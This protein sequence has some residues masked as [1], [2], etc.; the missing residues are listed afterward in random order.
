MT[1]DRRPTR[2]ARLI[3]QPTEAT[4]HDAPTELA[5]TPGCLLDIPSDYLDETAEHKAARRKEAILTLVADWYGSYLVGRPSAVDHQA[6]PADCLSLMKRL[7]VRAELLIDL[8]DGD[9][10]GNTSTASPASPTATR[11]TNTTATH[12]AV[13]DS[14]PPDQRTYLVWM[15]AF[16]GEAVP[17]SAFCPTLG[18]ET[19]SVVRRVLEKAG[20]IETCPWEDAVG[21]RVSAAGAELVEAKRSESRGMAA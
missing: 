12:A 5:D 20:L 1:A 8:I 6:K 4:E 11:S 16:D 9:G 21:F 18:P 15:A 17:P 2:P 10:N 13:F 3:A 19:S 7:K 14:V